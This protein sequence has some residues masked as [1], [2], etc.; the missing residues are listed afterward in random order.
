M[1]IENIR[2]LNNPKV[3]VFGNHPGIIQSILDFDYLSGKENPG[4]SAIIGV[5]NKNLRFFRLELYYKNPKAEKS[6]ILA[7]K[8]P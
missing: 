1:N 3:V 6:K 7:N 8:K 5:Q 2:K 4:V